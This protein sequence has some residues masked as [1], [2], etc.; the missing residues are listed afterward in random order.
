MDVMQYDAGKR[1]IGFTILTR[2]RTSVHLHFYL[3]IITQYVH[4]IM[5]VIQ[6]HPVCK[7]DKSGIT[8]DV[9]ENCRLFSFVL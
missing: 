7:R 4:K 6:N 5:K 3:F 1:A 8:A 9:Y 2:F